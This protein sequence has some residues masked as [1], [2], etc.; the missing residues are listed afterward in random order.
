MPPTEDQMLADVNSV[1]QDILEDDDLVLTPAF[2]RADQPKWDS[3][4]HLNLIMA[5]EMKYGVKYSVVEIEKIQS[6]ADLLSVT[7][8]K[9]K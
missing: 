5:M 7:Q 1:F 6:V 8:A 3:M 9:L 4:N 2:A